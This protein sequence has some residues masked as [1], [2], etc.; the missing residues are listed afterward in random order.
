MAVGSCYPFFVI[1]HDNY[2]PANIFP[3]S[4]APTQCVVLKSLL[5]FGLFLRP[6]EHNLHKDVFTFVF[7]F[8]FPYDLY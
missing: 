2:L 4:D 7:F 3:D 6:S 1:R 5:T 8:F